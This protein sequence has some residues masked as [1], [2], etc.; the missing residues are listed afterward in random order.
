VRHGAFVRT[1]GHVIVRQRP[2]TAKGMCFLTLEDE[3]GLTNAFL[4]PPIYERFRVLLNTSALLVVA[5]VLEHRDGVIHVRVRTLER[6][7]AA[8]ALPEGHDYR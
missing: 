2:G 3:T 4:T 7:S 5:G 6:L 8:A 1:A